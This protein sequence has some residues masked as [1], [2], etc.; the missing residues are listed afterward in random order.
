[1]EPKDIAKRTRK[2]TPATK[3]VVLVGHGAVAKDCPREWVMKL[4]ALEVRRHQ[5][6][7]EAVPE[8]LELDRR[9][10]T[11]PRTPEN[12]PYKTG[13][14]SLANHLR[15]GLNGT[16]LTVAYNEFCAPSLTEAVHAMIEEGVGV[17][18]VIP[19]MMTPG[20]V[21]SEVEIPVLL[22]QLR[23][24]NPEAR[25]RYIWPFDLSRVARL[26]V[27]HIEQPG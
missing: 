10:R 4:K 27:E 1:M 16:L 14:E 9:I 2:L 20:G 22:D 11:W 25:I 5:T 7:A 18:T 17:I 13:L 6:G 8:E 3:G 12:D 26:L 23:L 15:R 21:H 24:R 19:T